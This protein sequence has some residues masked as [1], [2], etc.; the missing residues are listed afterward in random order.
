MIIIVNALKGQLGA[1]QELDFTELINPL[2]ED[3]NEE[4]SPNRIELVIRNGRC[5][6]FRDMY[7]GCH[8]ALRGEDRT[9]IPEST[10]YSV[11]RM[12]SSL[13][14]DGPC[15]GELA[16]HRGQR[17]GIEPEARRIPAR[18]SFIDL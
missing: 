5:G 14:R 6:R 15:V 12:M 8:M 17:Y 13:Q 2:P 3:G 7:G 16:E 4:H 10:D 1:Y 18:A 11:L 9:H